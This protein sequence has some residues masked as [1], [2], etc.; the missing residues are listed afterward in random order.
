MISPAAVYAPGNV[1]KAAAVIF[2][3]EGVLS[4][5]PEEFARCQVA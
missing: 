1:T 3:L 5:F 2:T 4:V